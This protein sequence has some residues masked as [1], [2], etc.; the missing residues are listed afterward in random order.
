MEHKSKMTELILEDG[1]WKTA[2]EKSMRIALMHLRHEAIDQMK[3]HI[4]VAHQKL[5]D[6]Q[7]KYCSD[8]IDD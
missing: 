2:D 5:R 1:W 8:N 7:F 4:N 6:E 3:A